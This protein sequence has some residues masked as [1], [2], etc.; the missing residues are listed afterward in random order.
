M[1]MRSTG[2][3]A[4]F[5]ASNSAKGF[6]SYYGECFDHPRIGQVY[7]VKGGPGTGKSHFLRSVAEYGGARGWQC[8]YVYCSSDPQSLD[9]VILSCGEDCVA[10]L[11]A[12]APHVYEP[13]HPGVRENLINLGD[14]WDREKLS[15]S[16][17][18]ISTLNQEKSKAF[19][20]A[21][22]YLAGVGD[23][24]Q[25]RD[26]L[27]APFVRR[28]RLKRFAEHVAGE[29]SKGS[30][31]SVRPALIKSVGMRGQVAFDTYFAQASQI[32][33]VE[34][35]R[36]VGQYLM[37][38]LGNL[39]P[40]KQWRML[41]SHDPICP[42]KIDGLFLQDFGIAIVI[43]EKG[44]CPYPHRTLSM[45]RFVDTAGL[46]KVR[47]SLNYAERMRRAMMEGAVESMEQVRQ[48]HFLLESIYTDAMDFDAKEKFT[49]SFCERLFPLQ[50]P[51]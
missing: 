32:L 29:I 46:K 5:A 43:C 51:N 23:M 2:E 1:V 42:Q 21:Y 49:K 48:S 7:A 13:Q 44:E 9:G 16:A 18:R 28:E 37:A 26:E 3:R 8:E 50:N 14:F 27:V 39:A 17:D 47:I 24:V 38:E 33:R 4:Y 36:G 12:T 31:F 10:L 20:L 34:D 25:T 15:K 35:C 30:G 40:G 41:I 6:F 45:R 11:D 19:R 22:R